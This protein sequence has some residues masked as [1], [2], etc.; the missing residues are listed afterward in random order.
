MYQTFAQIIEKTEL[1]TLLPH[2]GKMFL[3]D[4]VTAWDCEAWTLE[5]ETVLDEGFMF[6]DATSSGIPA[7]AVFELM[8]QSV[9]ALTSIDARIHGLPTNMGMIL[10][11]TAMHF[12][13]P[14]LATGST[15][16]VRV[17]RDAAVDNVYSFSGIVYVGG[18]ECAHGKITVMEKT[19]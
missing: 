1:S 16:T 10:S 11:V 17:H 5:S 3:L 15:A 8:A 7:W 13:Q 19:D 18:A 6:Y 2:K 4:R 14:L 12:E 9:S